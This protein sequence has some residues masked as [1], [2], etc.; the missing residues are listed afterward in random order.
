M[1]SSIDL[2][3]DDFSS[4]RIGGWYSGPRGGTTAVT[5]A[6]PLPGQYVCITLN[7]YGSGGAI[8]KGAVTWDEFQNSTLSE[9]E[10][11]SESL[12]IGVELHPKYAIAITETL[13]SFM[14]PYDN[15]GLALSTYEKHA[16]PLSE[17]TPPGTDSF[18][19][20]F[21]AEIITRNLSTRTLYFTRDGE[22]TVFGDVNENDYRPNIRLNP[23]RLDVLRLEEHRLVSFDESPET[24]LAAETS[25]KFWSQHLPESTCSTLA[26]ADTFLELLK[27]PETEEITFQ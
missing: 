3:P 10:R 25:E 21:D 20:D 1:G 9:Q 14:K 2:D 18:T 7:G 13:E 5:N 26:A 17:Y 4:P 23:P 15:T 24:H 6:E 11:I 12:D 16:G 27:N 19:T 8:P 22:V